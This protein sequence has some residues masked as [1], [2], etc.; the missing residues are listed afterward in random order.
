ME[1]RLNRLALVLAVGAAAAAGCAAKPPASRVVTAP[2]PPPAKRH[3]YPDLAALY[4]G[5][6]GIYRTCATNQGVCHNDKEY[7]NLATLGAVVQTIGADCNVT[8]ENPR[9][10]HDL[11]ERPGDA[12]VLGGEP[13]EIG[14]VM[15]PPK[16]IEDDGTFLR[17][18]LRKKPALDARA[19]KKRV[20]MVRSAEGRTIEL[21]QVALI[22][23]STQ[24]GMPVVD[25]KL[26][27]GEGMLMVVPPDLEV[28]GDWGGSTDPGSLHLGDPNGNGKYGAELGGGLIVPGM[29]EKSYLLKRLVDPSAGPLMPRANCCTWSKES[30]RALYCWIAGL[31]PDGKNALGPIDYD[32]CPPGPVED[33]VYP[34]AGPSCETSGKCPVAARAAGPSADEA[35]ATGESTWSAV[36]KTVLSKRCAGA[37]CHT[38]EARASFD[39]SSE[40]SAFR[41]AQA[42]LVARTPHESELYVR[43]SPALCK[44]PACT[45]MPMR[46]APLDATMRGIVRRW[47]ERGAP[48]D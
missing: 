20:A 40:A 43:I 1:G 30:L 2:A 7:P 31:A 17:L 5:D 6:V 42:H 46:G 36:W 8:R 4:G 48:K 41:A 44:P 24:K 12:I 10:V 13:I 14:G 9:D 28:L 21:G 23:T 3:R 35:S 34:E 26:P 22:A 37:A 29:P 38:G 47:I 39:L 45:P 16:G 11:C 18:F 25:L 19:K 33:V 27:Y 32:R 15:S